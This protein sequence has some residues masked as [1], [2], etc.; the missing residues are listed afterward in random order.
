MAAEASGNQKA[1]AMIREAEEKCTARFFKDSK[2]EEAVE[3]FSNAAANLKISKD[4]EVAAKAYIRASEVSTL[5][6]EDLNAAN[7]MTEAAK[8]YKNVSVKDSI[9]CFEAVAKLHLDTNRGNLAARTYKSIAE[10]QEKDGTAK[11]IIDAYDAASVLFKAQDQG[12]ESNSCSL[13]VADYCALE[14]EYERAIKLYE[15]VAAASL[16]NKLLAYSVKDY[17]FKAALCRF[18][19]EA[20]K[21]DGEDDVNEEFKELTDALEKYKTNHPAFDDSRECKFIEQLFKMY[22]EA[23]VEKFTD[24]MFKYDKIYKLDKWFSS[25]LFVIKKT[26]MGDHKGDKEVDLQAAKT[27][28]Q[29]KAAA[30]AAEQKDDEPNLQG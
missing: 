4:W 11:N 19:F 23:D 16:E 2:R 27:T 3:L 26:L 21:W 18:A 28:K 8:A 1:L 5:L 13:K 14:G 9:R 12:S 7:Y 30:K 10:L 25:I 17:Y 22:A 29:K 15:E 20:K 24:V 6:K